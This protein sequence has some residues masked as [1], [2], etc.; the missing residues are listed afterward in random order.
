MPNYPFNNRRPSVLEEQAY[1]ET[2]R[3]FAGHLN[4]FPASREAVE[5]LE[6][7]ATKSIPIASSNGNPIQ[8][9]DGL[10]WHKCVDL[11][12]NVCLC[13]RP[14]D[15]GTEYAVVESSRNGVSEIV[16]QG[17]TAGEVIWAFAQAQRQALQL[18]TEDVTARV[19]EFLAGI[20][21]GQDMGRVE[22]SFIHHLTHAASQKQTLT[23]DHQHRHQRGIGI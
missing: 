6:R 23:H 22:E 19:K 12:D 15:S 14:T 4:Q 7:T 20:Y 9:G 17:H 3:H 10:Q 11:L 8:I 1:A 21:P 18:W 5:Q 2:R 16:C 13:Q